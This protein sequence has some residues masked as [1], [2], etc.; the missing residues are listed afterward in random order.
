[1]R[2]TQVYGY[3]ALGQL[4]SHNGAAFRYDAAG[5]LTAQPSGITQA[6]NAGGELTSRAG[7][8]RFRV[9]YG[10]DRNGERT[11]V[12]QSAHAAVVLGYDQAGRLVRYGTAA[13]YAYNGDGLRVSKTVGTVTT[14]FTWDQTA[15]VPLL[16]TAGAVSF[17]YGPGGQPVEQIT[18]A[19]PGYLF[20]D[21][22][23]STRLITSPAGKV[24]GTYTYGPYGAATRHTGTASTALQYDGQYTDAES[25]F[26][27]LQARYYDPATG[28]FLTVDPAVAVTAAPYGYA[29]GDPV[30]LAD[31]S[32]L[33][34][35][36][37][38]GA[39]GRLVAAAGLTAT[40]EFCVTFV[41]SDDVA[42]TMTNTVGVA[43]G[44]NAGA[45]G[46]FGVTL[47]G[48]DNVKGLAGRVCSIGGTIEGEVGIQ[49]SLTGN[50]AG[51]PNAIEVDASLGPQIGGSGGASTGVT[52][53]L[54]STDGYQGCG[55]Q[56]GQSGPA[57]QTAFPA[58]PEGP[59]LLN[60]GT[61]APPPPNPS[62]YF[63]PESAL[64]GSGT[65]APADQPA[66]PV[67][68]Y[69]CSNI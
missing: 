23:G 21:A 33:F 13:S 1:V 34:I 42:F 2:G 63:T 60:P 24:T 5:D 7:P 10:Y 15:P 22:H 67:A 8:G 38:G 29:G 46:F 43:G 66:S 37:C 30:N 32:G 25:G 17:V 9:S 26:Q 68:P 69:P 35:G 11:K 36:F 65:G 47:G 41:G 58:W 57:Q 61:G 14:T 20:A 50:C 39:T 62:T 55:G 27:Y 4:A 40:R 59:V 16:L 6:Y 49:G 54:W 28:Q 3:T 51:P 53:V 44:A 56:P 18:G 31:P 64:P 45:G 52:C 48:V 12:S 19:T